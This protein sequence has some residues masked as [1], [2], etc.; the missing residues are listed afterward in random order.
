M[1]RW[2][3]VLVVLIPFVAA[4]SS[5]SIA[6]RPDGDLMVYEKGSVYVCQQPD[7]ETCEKKGEPNLE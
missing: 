2:F 1:Y 5:S 7:F 3:L 6:V 4:C